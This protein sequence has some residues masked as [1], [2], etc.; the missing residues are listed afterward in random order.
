ML[1]LQAVQKESPLEHCVSLVLHYHHWQRCE[2][3]HH[4]VSPF[5]LACFN[6]TVNYTLVTSFNEEGLAAETLTPSWCLGRVPTFSG[7]DGQKY[8]SQ[9]IKERKKYKEC[10]QKNS[11]AI[12]E[13]HSASPHWG[14]CVA[15]NTWPTAFFHATRGIK[16]LAW[17]L[18]GFLCCHHWKQTLHYRQVNKHRQIIKFWASF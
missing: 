14:H 15:S 3:T 16:G 10:R 8:R 2:H 9:H 7:F 18:F 5:V 4:P 11:P 13:L 1:I 17:Y 12:K 6:S